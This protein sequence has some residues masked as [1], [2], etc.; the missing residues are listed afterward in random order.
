M[1]PN[2]EIPWD[3]QGLINLIQAQV[4]Q[5]VGRFVRENEARA[6]G[7]SI[8]ERIIRV[9]EA[10][11]AQGKI[12]E[13]L[14][15]EIDK[16]FSLLPPSSAC[17]SVVYP[18]KPIL[19]FCLTGVEIPSKNLFPIFSLFF[20]LSYSLF[21]SFSLLFPLSLSS[22][23]LGTPTCPAILSRHCSS[24]RRRTCHD[25]ALRRRHL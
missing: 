18:V 23:L 14:Q 22:D 1:N 6:R 15:R 5:K 21:P 11:V 13:S 19:I 25:V 2:A 7:V 20:P 10:L 8:M 12:L 16:R 3:R 9:E 4:A 24:E 17:R